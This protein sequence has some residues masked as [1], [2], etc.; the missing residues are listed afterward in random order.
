MLGVEFVEDYETK[1]PAEALRD[2]VIKKAFERG[3]LILGCGK[4]TIRIAPPLSV[5]KGEIDA[6][7]EIFDEVLTLAEEESSLLHVA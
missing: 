4:S 7:L 3:L 2:L 6:A 1:K 5:T